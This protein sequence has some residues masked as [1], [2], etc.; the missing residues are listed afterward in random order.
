MTEVH[1]AAVLAQAPAHSLSTQ[2]TLLRPWQALE[3]QQ[4]GSS[5][6]L[7]VRVADMMLQ[8]SPEQLLES[9]PIGKYDLSCNIMT[10]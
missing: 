1:A 3:Q 10:Y 7:L 8:F 6:V 4:D 5:T 2:P 9:R